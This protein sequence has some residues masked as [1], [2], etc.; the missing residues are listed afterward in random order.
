M[1]LLIYQESEHYYSSI[2]TILKFSKSL[3]SALS[4]SYIMHYKTFY[5]L[6][7]CLN[8]V[9]LYYKYI[10]NIL[11]KEISLTVNITITNYIRRHI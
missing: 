8:H 6:I 3:A 10:R 1:V 2:P 4:V 11:Q 7:N 5:N 9:Y